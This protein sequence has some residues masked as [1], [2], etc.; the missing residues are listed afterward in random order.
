[1]RHAGLENRG[2]ASCA[3]IGRDLPVRCHQR[4]PRW[5]GECRISAGVEQDRVGTQGGNETG[6]GGGGGFPVIYSCTNPSVVSA[7]MVID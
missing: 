3:W 2:K 4:M 6:G 5:H 1:M 7:L